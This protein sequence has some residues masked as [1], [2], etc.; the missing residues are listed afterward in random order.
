LDKD[1]TIDIDAVLAQ[2]VKFRAIDKFEPEWFYNLRRAGWDFY[3]DS[4]MPNRATNVWRY[5]EPKQYLIA[6][7]EQL[8]DWLPVLQDNAPQEL[9]P[10]RSEHAAF[11]YNRSDLRTFTQMTPELG[12]SGVI[13]K[14]LFSAIR[15]NSD[16]TGPH[17]GKLI[18]PDFGKFE[19]F[20]MAFW[21]NGLFLYIPKNTV[22]E[23]PIYLHRHPTGQ[24][25]IQ[26]LLIVIDENSQATIIDDY[27]CH[28][29]GMGM[30]TNSAIELFVGDASNA[31]YVNLQRLGPDSR[32]YIVKRA[33]IGQNSSLHSVFSGTGA[34][35]TKVNAGTI[36]A[37]RGANSRMSGVIFGDAN[38]H[39]DYHTVQNHRA[40]E[41]FSNLDFRVVLKDKSLSAYTGLIRI[42]KDTVNCE[43]YQENRNLLLN[44]GARAESIP[45]L[46]IMTDQ[47]R[48]T[49]GATMGPIDPE[50]VFYLQSRGYNRA[51]AVKSIVSG[52]MEPTFSQIPDDIAAILRE[53]VNLKLD[54][55]GGGGRIH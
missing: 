2:R 15:E 1:L 38:Q 17:L 39:F 31:R 25:T 43:A 20:N 55:D 13:F 26:R 32:P 44:P 52:F 51:E 16:I 33:Q 53:I 29:R 47:V 40:G 23:K 50:Q 37:G 45:E 28:C 46:E 9:K 41:S 14:D 19:A 27:S 3:N 10:M 4:P 8:M 36:L 42:E 24:Y 35:M 21:N 18:G 12:G 22:I 48:C 5:T 54:G 6:N 34:S 11:G 49:H 7:P 30:V